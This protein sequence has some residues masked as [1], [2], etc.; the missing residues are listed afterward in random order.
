MKTLI[1]NGSP[2]KN[3]DT[4]CMIQKLK[5]HLGGEIFQIDCFYEAIA[6]CC[7]CRSC[8]TDSCCPIDDKM[9]SIYSFI[10]SCDN[11]IIASPVHNAG[12]SSSLLSVASRFQLFSSALIFRHEKL[13]CNK[14]GAVLLAQ[15]GSGG[16]EKAFDIACLILRSV[17]ADTIFPPVITYDT[18]HTPASEDISLDDKILA[19][20]KLL[21][22]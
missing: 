18:D 15:G 2:R 11:I 7:D 12:L 6:P 10:K 16:A 19:L 1:L 5:P 17:G 14:K 13:L 4:V 20:A 22:E 8:R 21:N 3:G 9:Q